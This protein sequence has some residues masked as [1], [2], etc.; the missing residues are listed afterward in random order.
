MRLA[1][2]SILVLAGLTTACGSTHDLQATLVPIADT[3]IN[4]GDKVNHGADP[5]L[6]VGY[7]STGTTNTL[8]RTYVKFDLPS[9]QAMGHQNTGILRCSNCASHWRNG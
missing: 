3:T 8:H 7:E 4:N 9:L 2:G 1:L 6:H 5:L